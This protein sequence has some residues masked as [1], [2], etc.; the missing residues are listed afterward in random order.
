[1]FKKR[2]KQLEQQQLKLCA[3]IGVDD[4]GD[5]VGIAQAISKIEEM[6]KEW[7]DEK[8]SIL[9]QIED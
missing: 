1:M 8:E 6:Q 2:K 4:P 7:D 5:I 9:K 3:Q